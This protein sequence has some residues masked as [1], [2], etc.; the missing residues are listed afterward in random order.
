LRLQGAGYLYA[1]AA[2]REFMPYNSEKLK[3]VREPRLRD[4]GSLTSI[5]GQVGPE[6]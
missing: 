2:E 6:E 4:L 3:S 5:T 1:Q